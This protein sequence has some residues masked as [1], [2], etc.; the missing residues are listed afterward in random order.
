[1]PFQHFLAN[2]PSLFAGLETASETPAPRVK[3]ARSRNRG[4]AWESDL[5]R[6]AAYLLG[7]AR[8]DEER[9][10]VERLWE[11]AAE[12]GPDFIHYRSKSAFMEAPK[13]GIDRNA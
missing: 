4:A 7:Q 5:S 10:F 11:E 9:A 2:Q 8:N 12:E 3:S 6:M 13:L 1:M